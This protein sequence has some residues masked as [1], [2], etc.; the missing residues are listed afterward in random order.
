MPY[1]YGKYLTKKEYFA[2]VGDAKQCFGIYPLLYTAGKAS[3]ISCYD[4]DNAGGLRFSV[5][6]SK[7]LDLFSFTYKGVPFQF[8]TKAGLSSP[9]IAQEQGMA[10]R[11]NLGAGFM[12]TAGLSHVGLGCED[13]GFY[14]NVHG[15][16]KNIP[17]E[18]VAWETCW[19]GDSCVLKIS[20]ET[21]DSAFFGRNL[22]LRREISTPVGEHRLFIRDFIENR[23]FNDEQIMLLYHMNL[24]YPVL[25]AGTRLL[26]PVQ[27]D[28]P[29]SEHTKGNDQD[30]SVMIAP[31]DNNIEYLH[32]LTLKADENGR[33]LSVAW[34]PDMNLGLYVRYNT[35]WLKHLIE[36][37]CMSSGD[38]ALGML[39]STCIPIG[40]AANREGEDFRTL[41]PFA[42]FTNTLEIGVVDGTEEY[43]MLQREIADILKYNR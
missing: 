14:H 3:F 10:Y 23:G 6:E 2:H 19:D 36:W 9:W 13:N 38:Y 33:T 31:I 42:S 18:N 29:L 41:A 22:F 39:P 32:D 16:L 8:V 12:Y 40:R 15:N 34:N 5:N 27:C 4:V 17:A 35:D 28:T 1:I 24:G 37:K 26:A 7:N 25:D 43:M 11:N 21:Y 30:Y 20:G